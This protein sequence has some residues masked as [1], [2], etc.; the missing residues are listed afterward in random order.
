MK[1]ISL[2]CEFKSCNRIKRLKTIHSTNV[3]RQSDPSS[4]KIQ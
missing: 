1:G 4:Y 2:T 3:K